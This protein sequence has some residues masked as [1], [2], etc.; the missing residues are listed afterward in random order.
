MASKLRA[1]AGSESNGRRQ[2]KVMYLSQKVELLDRLAG[3]ETAASV[4][5]HYDVNESTVRS[6]RKNEIAIRASVAASIPKSAKVLFITRD[7]KLE[8]MEKTLNLWI[9]DQTQKRVSLNGPV[10]REKAKQLYEDLMQASGGEGSSTSSFLASKGWFENFKKRYN[11]QHV[12]FLGESA[13][14]DYVAAQNFLPQLKKIIKKKGYRPEQVFN[15]DETGLFWK[16]M[17]SRKFISKE[18]R[19]APC[20]KAAKDRLTLLL[21][22]NASGD[23]MVKPML[24]FRALNPRVLKGKKKHDLPVFW[25][26][27]KRACVTAAVFMDWFLNCFVHEVENYLSSQSLAFKVL[28]ILDN[29]PG[30]PENIQFAHPNVEVLF[31]PPN[32]AALLQPLNQGVIA[33]FKTY[34][35]RRTFRHILDT[36]GSDPTLN[37]SQCW[38]DYNIADCINNIRDSLKDVKQATINACW[39]KLWKEEVNEFGS[40]PSV[41]DEVRR[42]AK[43]ARDVGGDE[44]ADLEATEIKE[45]II[46]SH[47]EALTEEDS[48]ELIKS[49]E[50]DEDSEE[51]VV[52]KPQLNLK[53]L[54]E[55]LQLAKALSDRVFEVDP[56]MA[57]SIKFKREVEDMIIPYKKVFKDLQK[58]AKQVPTTSFS[59]PVSS[60]IT[61][62]SPSSSTA[63]VGSSLDNPQVGPSTF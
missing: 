56:F 58:K 5:R 14:A 61:P 50:G 52:V 25:P 20:F 43:M 38:K 47:T 28:L 33:A 22:A 41:D 49:S 4:G 54:S 21:C 53:S 3:G 6:I 32:T 40:F 36:M 26:S 11:L 37:V 15:A 48:E 17:P 57:R 18:E 16:K 30:H 44:F 46:R 42:I 9:E 13:S 60:I 24:L 12:K 7:P 51:E 27:N 2:K 34:Y 1:S 35:T 29:A 62:R 39:G 8:K 10:I 55:V 63:S 45:L 19:S 31:L 59:R 23:F